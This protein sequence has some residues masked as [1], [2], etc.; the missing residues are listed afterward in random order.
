MAAAAADAEAVAP[1][2][3]AKPGAGDEAWEAARRAR[4]A[5]EEAQAARQDLTRSAQ[6]LSESAERSGAAVAVESAAGAGLPPGASKA[7]AEERAAGGEGSAKGAGATEKVPQGSARGQGSAAEAGAVRQAA[8]ADT[9][10]NPG[11]PD[12]ASESGVGRPVETPAEKAAKAMLA[13][14][15]YLARKRKAPG[16]AVG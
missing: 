16:L 9:G 4:E 11:D 5:Y 7:V 6:G 13:R 8:G 14:E 2:G 10:S 12:P 3:G 15:R 1:A